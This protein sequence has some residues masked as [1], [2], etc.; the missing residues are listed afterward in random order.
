MWQYDITFHALSSRE[1]R[2]SA[3]GVP[4]L[5]WVSGDA[6]VSH[7]T[8]STERN[9]KKTKKQNPYINT[10]TELCNI[11][12]DQK[13]LSGKVSELG[14]RSSRRVCGSKGRRGHSGNRRG[15]D[16]QTE[17]SVGPTGATEKASG[18][19]WGDLHIELASHYRVR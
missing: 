1:K 8:C 11:H 9:T 16:V 7:V 14:L 13:E 15:R 4:V 18:N 19:V 17:M 6:K 2:S 5:N 10:V 12:N 3:Y